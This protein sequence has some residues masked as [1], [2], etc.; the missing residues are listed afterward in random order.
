MDDGTT[1]EVD[2]DSRKHE[3]S[4]DVGAVICGGHPAEE[5]AERRDI[6][7]NDRSAVPLLRHRF[8]RVRYRRGVVRWF[9]GWFL[10][11][12][13]QRRAVECEQHERSNY[14]SGQTYPH[15]LL[16]PT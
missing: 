6:R 9:V 3:S 16:P 5:Q 7:D 8:F 1:Q 12:S 10:S 13:H 2:A 15:V 4:T 11:P 14:P